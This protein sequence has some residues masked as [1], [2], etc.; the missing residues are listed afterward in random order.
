MHCPS[1][2]APAWPTQPFCVELLRLHGACLTT[3]ATAEGTRLQLELPVRGG[4][5]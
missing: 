2:A 5:A 4:A 3:V 1:A